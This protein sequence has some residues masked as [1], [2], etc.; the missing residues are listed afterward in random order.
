MS[1]ISLLQ[2]PIIT[3]DFK[4]F[5][6]FAN[7]LTNQV[8]TVSVAMLSFSIAFFK[9]FPKNKAWILGLSW[10]LLFF[11]ILSG[12]LH[13]MALTG[14]I[15]TALTTQKPPHMEG[16]AKCF[17]AAQLLFF[18]GGTFFLVVFGMRA[19]FLNQKAQRKH[20]KDSFK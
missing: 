8:L 3:E 6:D 4:T 9:D 16:N 5:L 13:L 7:E 1:V 14:I 19:L 2:Q 11:S 15:E 17:A 20:K 12:T 18:L 10:I